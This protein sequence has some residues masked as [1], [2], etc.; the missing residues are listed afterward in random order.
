M[1]C[2]RGSCSPLH[3]CHS[4]SPLGCPPP[5]SCRGAGARRPKRVQRYEGGERSRYFA[6]DDAVDLA[7]LAK[8]TKHGEERDLDA[9]LAAGIARAGTRY[10]QADFDAGGWDGWWWFGAVV[11]GQACRCAA[12]AL[13]APCWR[14]GGGL[15]LHVHPRPPA[16]CARRLPLP[17]LAAAQPLPHHPHRHCCHHC[18]TARP[19]N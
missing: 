19:S 12:V 15:H 4:P 1:C 11:W 17:L 14:G 6:D 7:T 3:A 9:A 5:P 16:S 10:K 8:R 13:R 18:P 2:F